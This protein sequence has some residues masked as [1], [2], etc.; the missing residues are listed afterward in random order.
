MVLSTKLILPNNFPF[1]DRNVEYAEFFFIKKQT[2]NTG[3]YKT[4]VSDK[5]N[6]S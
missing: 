6:N 3:I 1:F 2:L 4:C 5:G